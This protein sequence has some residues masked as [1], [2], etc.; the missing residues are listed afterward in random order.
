MQVLT[1]LGSPRKSGN[2]ATV[3]GWV[4]EELKGLG[5]EIDRVD[6][7]DHRIDGCIG[8][9]A[10]AEIP[11]E[12]GC[13]LGD[14]TE[15]IFERMIPTD[16]ILFASPLYMWGFASQLK[17]FLDRCA[18]LVKDY[19][20]PNYKSLI[21]GKKSAL[22][23]T[24]MG[25]LEKADL[26]QGIYKRFAGYAQLASVGELIVPNCTEPDQLAEDAKTQAKALARQIVG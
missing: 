9:W 1:I 20:G 26:I 17:A 4:E 21:G 6:V 15:A 22:L 3:L 24:C 25:P 7:I 18:C 12:P 14:G 19:G 23:V 11:D 10:C 13:V 2:T 8:C 5:H 16:A